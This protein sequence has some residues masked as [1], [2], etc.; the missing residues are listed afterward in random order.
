MA[1]LKTFDGIMTTLK[2]TKEQ[3]DAY[4]RSLSYG[5]FLRLCYERGVKLTK[6]QLRAAQTGKK[7]TVLQRKMG[8]TF[9]EMVFI[10]N[11]DQLPFTDLQWLSD[12]AS[13]STAIKKRIDMRIAFLSSSPPKDHS[14]SPLSS[15]SSAQNDKSAEFPPNISRER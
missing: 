3:I 7:D 13:I 14:S 2:F 12:R 9:R 10:E 8:N 5:E 6:E 15:L 4:L 11:L 1:E